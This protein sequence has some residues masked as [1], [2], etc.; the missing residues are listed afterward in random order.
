MKS[1]A[2][3]VQQARCSRHGYDKIHLRLWSKCEFREILLPKILQGDQQ[4]QQP[5]S[6]QLQSL[7]DL[8]KN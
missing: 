6:L 7:L 3:T 8:R 1:A 2:G 5:A 4:A